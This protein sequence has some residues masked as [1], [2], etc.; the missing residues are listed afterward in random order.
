MVYYVGTGPKQW[1]QAT[2]EGN[3]WIHELKWGFFF[4]D[5]PQVFAKCD[6]KWLTRYLWGPW[7]ALLW[8]RVTPGLLCFPG[9]SPWLSLDSF[10]TASLWLHDPISFFSLTFVIAAVTKSRPQQLPRGRVYSWLMAW[11]GT[12]HHCREGTVEEQRCDARAWGSW[13]HY[14]KK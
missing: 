11:E 6:R 14:S 8:M 9:E 3:L 7:G 13:L 10:L 4:S 5:F 1:R 12:V 2:M